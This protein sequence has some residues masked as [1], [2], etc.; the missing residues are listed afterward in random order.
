VSGPGDQPLPPPLAAAVEEFNAW[1]LEEL[2]ADEARTTPRSPLYHYTGE[3]GLR[4]I[5]QTQKLWCFIHNNQKDKKELH[6]SLD[7]GRQVIRQEADRDHPFAE[8]LLRGLDDLLANNPM[9]EIFDFYFFSFSAHRD[10]FSQWIDY[11]DEGKGFAIGF[12]PA[13]FRIDRYELA[14]CANEN[15]FVG[16]VVYGRDATRA[17]HRPGVRKLAEIAERVGRAHPRLVHETYQAWFDRM[18]QDF[19]ATMFIWNCL[20]AKADQFRSEQ[21]TRCI[22]LNVRS[23]FDDCRK[24]H[25]SRAYVELSR[26]LSKPG[27]ITEI[28]VGPHTGPCSEVMVKELLQSNGYPADILISRSGAKLK[29]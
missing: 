29:P 19:I 23:A 7:I 16:R 9:G 8:R 28:F 10:H 21:E 12:S 22:V 15:D 25:Y 5:L 13:L 6:Y 24:H 11:G 3:A 26:P 1:M 27:N 4:G 14:P 17:R 20:T 18:N 2:R